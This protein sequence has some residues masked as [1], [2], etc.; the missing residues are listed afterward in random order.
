MSDDTV[1]LPRS[2]LFGPGREGPEVTVTVTV[3]VTLNGVRVPLKLDGAALE[4]IAA[5][6]PEHERGRSQ[7]LTVAEAAEHLRA[8]PQRVYDLLSARRLSRYKDGRRVLVA[9]V[10]LDEHLARE[11]RSPVAPGLP[12]TRRG[13]LRKRLAT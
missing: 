13:G 9:R 10:E 6:L 2:W 12:P 5:A 11:A 3:T 4:A 8:K 1:V 7:Y